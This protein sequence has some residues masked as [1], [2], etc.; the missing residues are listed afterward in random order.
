M[1]NTCG[2]SALVVLVFVPGLRAD[3]SKPA[4]KTE[5]DPKVL[6]IVKQVGTLYKNAKS[7]QVEGKV[8]TTRD[9][10]GEK[11]Q[12]KVSM[13]YAFERPNQFA[14]R[15][16]LAEDKNAGMV[17]VSDGKTLFTHARR[18]KKYT[19]AST[20]E[21][22]ASIGRKLARFGQPSTGMLFQNILLEDPN[23]TLLDGVTSCKYVGNEKVGE[24]SAHHLT[25]TQ[26]EFNWDLWVA[27][28]GKPFVLKMSNVRS[29]DDAKVSTV[30]TYKNW[31]VDAPI[32]K[33][34]FAF[35]TPKDATKVKSLGTPRGDS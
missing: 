24:T 8:E 11:N 26:A 34:T 15:T 20:P 18:M 6:E 19:E 3:N 13:A 33:T 27:S 12:M 25:F 10:D 31:K 1:K 14:L 7:L 2:L 5:M 35:E 29:G 21:D 9:M 32:E 23:E 28:E 4:A 16:Q 17:M 30:E 22:I